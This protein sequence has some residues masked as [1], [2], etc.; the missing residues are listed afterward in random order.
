M[1]LFS[2]IIFDKA[3]D[4]NLRSAFK[5]DLF[6]PYELSFYITVHQTAAAEIHGC[7]AQVFVRVRV[8]SAVA[9]DTVDYRKDQDGCFIDRDL[10]EISRGIRGT[11]MFLY[12]LTADGE[13]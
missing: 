1:K 7:L 4:L 9:Y 12:F 8:Y 6:R 11:V 10:I 3:I 13:F 5:F 2:W